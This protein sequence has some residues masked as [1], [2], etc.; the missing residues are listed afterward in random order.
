ME[1]SK[2]TLLYLGTPYTHVDQSVMAARFLAVNRT[3]VKLI[4]DGF[5]VFSP[6]THGHPLALDG[7]LP[8]DW[9]YWKQYS[10]RMLS[11]CDAL[12]VLRVDGWKESK[13]LTEEIE[14]ANINGMPIWYREG[15]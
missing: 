14:F 6:I 3:A 1:Q 13:G 4:N 7:D 5:L 2:T 12:V 8:R 9:E 11:M 10:L 15:V